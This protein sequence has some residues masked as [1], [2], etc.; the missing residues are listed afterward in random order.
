[1][2]ERE[3]EVKS[4]SP[5][6]KTEDLKREWDYMSEGIGNRVR[7]SS[8]LKNKGIKRPHSFI[9]LWITK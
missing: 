5:S 1:M 6:A 3:K 4:Y 8:G 9:L 7:F 2:R